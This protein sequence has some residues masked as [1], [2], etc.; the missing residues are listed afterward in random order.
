MD[1]GATTGSGAIIVLSGRLA[2]AIAAEQSSAASVDHTNCDCPRPRPAV[3]LP[4]TPRVPMRGMRLA[5]ARV[6]ADEPAW[7]GEIG[8]AFAYGVSVSWCGRISVQ[9]GLPR[10]AEA[11]RKLGVAIASRTLRS[12]RLM[13]SRRPLPAPFIHER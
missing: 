2:S 4:A 6:V 10:P 7:R 9:A 13:T 1:R 12:A 5:Y 8:L 3:L 11:G